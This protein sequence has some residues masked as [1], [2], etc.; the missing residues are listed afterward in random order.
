MG[1]IPGLGSSRGKGNGNPLQD[2][3]TENLRDRGV[4]HATV[5]EVMKSQA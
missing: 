5:H 2:S 4:S 1:S 3:C